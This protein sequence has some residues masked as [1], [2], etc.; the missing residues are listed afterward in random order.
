MGMKSISKTLNC[1]KYV[2]KNCQASPGICRGCSSPGQILGHIVHALQSRPG[3][4]LNDYLKRHNDV[5]T[6]T[7][8][9]LVRQYKFVNTAISYYQYNPIIDVATPHYNNIERKYAEKKV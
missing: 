6:I 3:L 5:S 4:F 9:Q 7:H 2:I 8:L 1:L